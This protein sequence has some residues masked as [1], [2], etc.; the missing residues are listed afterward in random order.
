MSV[1]ME[2]VWKLCC[3]WFRVAHGFQPLPDVRPLLLSLLF[4]IALP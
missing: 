1:Q 3:A 4:F 2:I